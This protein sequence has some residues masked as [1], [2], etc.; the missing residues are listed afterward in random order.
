MPWTEQKTY[1]KSNIIT[2]CSSFNP[3]FFN[4][5]YCRTKGQIKTLS[6][7][8][9]KPP[10]KNYYQLK[11]GKN[12]SQTPTPNICEKVEIT[13]QQ[14]LIKKQFNHSQ[15]LKKKSVYAKSKEKQI[16]VTKFILL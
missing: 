12:D 11:L 15:D 14:Q 10:Q 1:R 2:N 13:N 4:F 16:N 9:I 6:Y 8:F 7:H 3:L 5:F